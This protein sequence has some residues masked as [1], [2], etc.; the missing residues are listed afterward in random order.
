MTALLITSRQIRAAR[1]LIGWSQAQ[2][3]KAAGISRSTIAAIEGD[4]ANPSADMLSKIRAVLEGE[5]VEFTTQEGVRLREPTIHY[6]NNP[7]ANRR[8]LADVY[9]ASLDYLEKENV[10]D[11]LIFGVREEDAEDSVGDYLEKHIARLR[12]AG[13][14]E[15]I[16]CS[17][18]TKMF[19]A[20]REWYRKLP[21]LRSKERLIP[22]MVYGEKIAVIT[23][24]PKETIVVVD[25]KPMADAFR[26]MFQHIWN[27][28]QGQ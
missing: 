15:K 4:T 12:A 21:E 25:S 24:Q 10:N 1:G 16:L 2:L 20:P 18:D 5:Q 19:L 22:V 3:A 23:W 26:L 14:E 6:D 17:P 11:I 9:T 8:L 7:G 13:L 28:R 27:S